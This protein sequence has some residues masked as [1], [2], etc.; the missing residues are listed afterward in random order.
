[1]ISEMIVR[2]NAHK[3]IVTF[4]VFPEVVDNIDSPSE[5]ERLEIVSCK[6]IDGYQL[7]EKEINHDDFYERVWSTYK[8]TNGSLNIF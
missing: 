5:K 7:S 8:A 4:K 2:Y 3:Y 6:C 1:M